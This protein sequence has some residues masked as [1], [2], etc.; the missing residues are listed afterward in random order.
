MSIHIGTSGW[1]YPH[2]VD[3]FY[4]V[5]GELIFKRL[6]VTGIARG[7]EVSTGIG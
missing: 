2:W 6:R 3:R 4:P 1:Q 7:N 5:H